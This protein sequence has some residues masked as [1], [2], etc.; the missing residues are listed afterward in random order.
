ML[1]TDT[2][3]RWM[4]NLSM[5]IKYHLRICQQ[6]G[7]W[8]RGS[9]SCFLPEADDTPDYFYCGEHAPVQGFCWSCGR[10]WGGIES[11][12]FRPLSLCDNCIDQYDDDN[13]GNEDEEAGYA[14][15]AT[16]P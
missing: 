13:E 8:A 7:C 5:T 14:D 9:I 15:K 11:F 1:Y 3:A 2:I 10:F 6:S 4:A 16:E 12:D